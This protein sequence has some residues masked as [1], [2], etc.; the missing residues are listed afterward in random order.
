M[1]HRSSGGYNC[2]ERRVRWWE[3]GEQS[4]SRALAINL[5]SIRQE[6]VDLLGG[7]ASLREGKIYESG[8]I[9]ERRN[10]QIHVIRAMS[11]M[12]LIYYR[13]PL[14]LHAQFVSISSRIAA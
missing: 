14:L 11:G 12:A 8:H 6:R 3:D 9:G 10:Y 1:V 13:G 7:S 5:E 2:A 4:I